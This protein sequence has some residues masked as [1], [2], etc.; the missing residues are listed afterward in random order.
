VSSSAVTAEEPVPVIW[1]LE[2]IIFFSVASLAN[3]GIIPNGQT[4]VLATK[5]GKN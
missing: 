3:H 2:S 1:L 4:R 5:Q